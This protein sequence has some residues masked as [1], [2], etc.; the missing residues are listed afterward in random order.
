MP[1][2]PHPRHHETMQAGARAV[3]IAGQA[4]VLVVGGG[5][6]GIGAAVGAAR[7]G[8]RTVL[9]ERYGFLGG[10]ATAGLVMPLM[11][12]FTEHHTREQKG[13]VSLLP[14][15]HGQGVPVIAG[16]LRE[17]IDRLE[18]AGG[19]MEPSLDTGFTVPFDPEVF[20]Q[21][22]VEFL[23]DAGVLYI[24]HS[25][26]GETLRTDS[27]VDGVVVETKSGPLAIRASVT[28]DCTGDGDT[29]AGGGAA[30]EMGRSDGYTQPMTLMFRV[31][32]FDKTAFGD[33]AG[34]H[35]GQWRGV[36]GLWDLVRKATRAGELNLQREDILFFT[37]MHEG[38]I[39]VNSTRVTKL[40][41]TDVWDLTQ[42][43]WESR[44]QMQQ[45]F[46]FLKKYVP[47]FEKSYI[48]QSGVQI[49][50]RE[51]RRVVGDYKLNKHDVL[52]ARQ[53]D[54]VIA[55]CT[56]PMDIHNP[57]G[58]GTTMMRVPDGKAYDIPL[59]C[60][61]PKGVDNLL[62]AGRC[63]SG[64]HEACSSYRIMPVSIATGQA[65]GV[66]AAMAAEAEQTPRSVPFQEVQREL[67][68]QNAD[69]RDIRI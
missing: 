61:L 8:A 34:K 11:S 42:A 54:D 66:C 53:F 45:I 68:K 36:H 37:A 57:K 63:I 29:A 50:V 19:A 64:T 12:Y 40:F 35:P 46:Q 2:L 4:D 15:D 59:R 1:P 10:N 3:R 49:G 65:A 20:K 51:T 52:C 47:G 25:L 6:A 62:V 21:A 32:G 16:V 55:R 26:A 13:A 23:D 24:F 44:R 17:M 9:A 67:L 58:K 30:F 18:R 43:E 22:A 38:E 31:M 7:A 56:Y 69:L 33:Y 14:T 27:R 39:T 28:V 48:V 41:G 5:P 60:L